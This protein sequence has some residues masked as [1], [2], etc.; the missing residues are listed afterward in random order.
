[1]PA[2]SG[3]TEFNGVGLY[4]E[5]ADTVPP[6]V[7]LHDGLLGCRVWDDQL[8]VFAREYRV[9]RYDVRGCGR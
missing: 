7:L 6:L 2:T 8:G 1:M 4:C 3:T 5:V 9:V